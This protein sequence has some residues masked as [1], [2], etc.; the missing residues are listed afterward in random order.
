[1]LQN[2]IFQGK[3]A[4]VMCLFLFFTI[5]HDH[6]LTRESHSV[7]SNSLR[8]HGLYSPW[9]SPS[10]NT[11]VGS[12]SLTPGDLPNPGVKP[13]SPALEADSLPSEPPGKSKNTGLG[14]LSLFQ[15]IFVTQESNQGI[16]HCRWILYQLSYQGSP[17]ISLC[18]TEDISQEIKSKC[19]MSFNKIQKKV[20]FT[21]LILNSTFYTIYSKELNTNEETCSSQGTSLRNYVYD[22]K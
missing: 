9:N 7:V 11:E 20:L 16:L 17:L 21:Y 4:Q 18:K 15:Q 13:R 14:N 5:P 1:M 2:M 22:E 8:P 12:H 10:Q 3:I 6:V 19:I